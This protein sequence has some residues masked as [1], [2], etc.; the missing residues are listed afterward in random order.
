MNRTPLL[1]GLLLAAAF[2]A[3]ADDQPKTKVKVTVAGSG[4]VEAS[5]FI[6]R[7][8]RTLGDVEIVSTNQDCSIEVVVLETKRGGNPIGYA[9]SILITGRNS[10]P[11]VLGVATKNISDDSARSI[12]NSAAIASKELVT[13][14]L[15]EVRTCPDDGLRKTCESIV[16]QFDTDHLEP[17]RKMWK[18]LQEQSQGTVRKSPPP[19]ADDPISLGLGPS[20]TTNSAPVSR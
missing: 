10:I 19:N 13:V 7:E 11:Y 20:R 17:G 1:L 12:V 15:H 6:T 8:L 5:S 3:L 14:L 4:S 18:D 2:S 9:L 16:A